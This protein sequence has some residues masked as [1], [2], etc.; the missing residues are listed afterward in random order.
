MPTEIT[1]F[2]NDRTILTLK[3]DAIEERRKLKQSAMPEHYAL[4]GEEQIADL[5]AFLLTLRHGQSDTQHPDKTN[6]EA[7]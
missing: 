2:R 6:I 5:T 7:P 1:V 3:A 4:F